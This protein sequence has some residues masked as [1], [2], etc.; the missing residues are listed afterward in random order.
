[1]EQQI[2][3]EESLINFSELWIVFRQKWYWVL[4][5]LTITISLAV[6]YILTTSPVYTRKASVLIKEEGKAKGLK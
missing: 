6:I 2:E 1:M 4:I 5:S 3:Q